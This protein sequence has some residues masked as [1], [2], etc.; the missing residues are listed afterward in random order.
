MLADFH[1]YMTLIARNMTMHQ[2][3]HSV[4]LYGCFTHTSVDSNDAWGGDIASYGHVSLSGS[5]LTS[6]LVAEI[7]GSS[8][9][10]GIQYNL[11]C[12][13]SRIGWFSRNQAENISYS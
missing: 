7:I 6:P 1:N 2:Q 5:G 3:Q 9:F 13:A 11:L 10:S 8:L 12:G 4:F